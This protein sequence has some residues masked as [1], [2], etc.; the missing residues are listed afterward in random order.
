MLLYLEHQLRS[1]LEGVLEY[2]FFCEAHIL[3]V[4]IL[5]LLEGLS[6]LVCEASFELL[7]I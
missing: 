5:E 1:E 3:A 2:S 4:V 7:V 6:L